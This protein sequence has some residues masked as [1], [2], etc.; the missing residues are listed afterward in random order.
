MDGIEEMKPHE[1]LRPVR[2]PGHL[3]DGQAGG[4]RSEDGGGRRVGRHVLED[5]NLES[6]V[7]RHRFD[8]QIRIADGGFEILG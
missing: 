3:G 8:D 1:S 4:I 2:G 5:P 6:H 7:F